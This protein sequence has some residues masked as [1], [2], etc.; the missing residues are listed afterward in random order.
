MLFI[1]YPY[2]ISALALCMY[3]PLDGKLSDLH[4][5][6]F[7]FPFAGS[8][9][10]TQFRGLVQLGRLLGTAWQGE[11]RGEGSITVLADRPYINPV[12]LLAPGC[13]LPLSPACFLHMQPANLQM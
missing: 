11:A 2:P 1:T 13:I 8:V 7:V 5:L 4:T 6:F 3:F 10:L 9:S 12:S